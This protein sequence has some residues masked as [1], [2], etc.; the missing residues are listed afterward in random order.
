ML[1]APEN[2]R[3]FSWLVVG[4]FACALQVVVVVQGDLSLSFSKTLSLSFLKHYS[5][6]HG[7]QTLN[8]I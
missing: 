8:N 4:F 3:F 5:I 2:I 1:P 7:S 6:Q